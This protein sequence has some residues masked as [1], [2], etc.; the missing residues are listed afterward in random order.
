MND[1]FFNFRNKVK[2]VIFSSR[3]AF[4]VNSFSIDICTRHKKSYYYIDQNLPKPDT[5]CQVRRISTVLNLRP[6]Y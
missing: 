3:R 2:S 4:I 6:L 1:R 5:R